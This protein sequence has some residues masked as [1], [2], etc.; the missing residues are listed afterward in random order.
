MNFFRCENGSSSYHDLLSWQSCK[1]NFLHSDHCSFYWFPDFHWFYSS[2]FKK[3]QAHDTFFAGIMIMAYPH[4]AVTD[5][6]ITF[7][8]DSD[9]VNLHPDNSQEASPV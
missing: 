2:D 7:A 1:R 4:S 9:I 5:F 3:D 8:D 6:V